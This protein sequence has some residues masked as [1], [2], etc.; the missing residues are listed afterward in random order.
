MTTP[1]ATLVCS[2]DLPGGAAEPLPAAWL[3]EMAQELAVC[4]APFTLALADLSLLAQVRSAVT[5]CHELALRVDEGWAG[6]DVR[7]PLFARTLEAQ[8]N[9][10]REQGVTVQTLA[11]GSFPLTTH[12]DLLVKHGI[13]AIRTL[14]PAPKA[15]FLPRVFRAPTVVADRAEIVRFGVCTVPAMVSWTYGQGVRSLRKPLIAAAESGSAHLVCDLRGAAVNQPLDARFRHSLRELMRHRHT[16]RA[17]VETV[18]ESAQRKLAPR[19]TV[20]A[21]SILRA[22]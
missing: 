2:I 15:A 6:P 16:V 19:R 3:R 22:A 11:W 1:R 7:R 18:V 14:A 9:M 8:L 13:Q 17:T 12:T 20:S 21:Q 10:A 4:E 5:D